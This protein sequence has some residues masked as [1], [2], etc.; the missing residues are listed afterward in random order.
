MLFR[1]KR[2]SGCRCSIYSDAASLRELA[3]SGEARNSAF[4][5]GANRA[6]QNGILHSN[7]RISY[8]DSIYLTGNGRGTYYCLYG[9]GVLDGTETG[10]SLGAMVK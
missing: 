4:D 2:A 1:S 8:A 3:E 7:S 6:G 10:A 5:Y 9:H